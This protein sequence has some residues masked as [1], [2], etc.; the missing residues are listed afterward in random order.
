MT[1]LILSGQ[2][3]FSQKFYMPSVKKGAIEDDLLPQLPTAKPPSAIRKNKLG[4]VGSAPSAG[5]STITFQLPANGQL[6]GDMY[7]Q[8]DLGAT[9]T[10]TYTAFPAL[11]LVTGVKISHGGNTLHEYNYPDYIQYVLATMNTGLK[12]RVQAAA[13][14]AA[15]GSAVSVYCPIG[16]FWT[17]YQHLHSDSPA[18]LPLNSSTV[19]LNIEITLNTVANLLT[20]AATGGSLVAVNLIYYSYVI[21]SE[22]NARI[23]AFVKQ[24]EYN[25]YGIDI[26]SVNRQTVATATPTDYDLS[27]LQGSIKQ[28]VLVNRLTTDLT[29]NNNYLNKG[30]TAYSLS[31]DGTQIMFV[32]GGANEM[33]MDSL[34]FNQFK[35]G[36]DVTMGTADIINF[37]RERENSAW[38]GDLNSQIYKKLNLNVTHAAGAGTQFNVAGIMQRY[39]VFRNGLFERV[40]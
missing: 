7:L 6:I 35:T 28:L 22:E 39:Y 30:L 40:K 37:G 1:D 20:A 38:A 26:Q 17:S 5:G 33:I 16:A 27:G 2:Q 18:P 13:G 21:P 23:Q 19:P 24:T 4:P 32:S 34:V 15:A 31:I 10:S 36:A 25:Q 12:A 11:N 9:S 8:A 3:Q 29:A 14:G